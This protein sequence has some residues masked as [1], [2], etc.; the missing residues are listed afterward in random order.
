MLAPPSGPASMPF[1]LPWSRPRALADAPLHTR[2]GG[3]A[4]LVALLAL[5]GLMASAFWLCSRPPL[6]DLPQHLAAARV[7][8]DRAHPGFRFEHFFEVDWWRSQYLGTYVLLGGAFR[9]LRP[10]VDRPMLAAMRGVLVLL[11]FAWPL[12]AELMYRKLGRRAGLGALASVFFFNVHLILGFLNFVLGIVACLLALACL[13]SARA[14]ARAGR[15]SRLAT[16][17]WSAS[18][19]ACF[20]LHVVPFALLVGL[21]TWTATLEIGLALWRRTR[22]VGPPPG[23]TCGVLAQPYLA[24]LPALA[25][26]VAWLYTPAGVSTREAARGTGARG[27][28]VYASFESNRAELERWLVDAFASPWDTRWAALALGLLALWIAV[29]AAAAGWARRTARQPAALA[30]SDPT[31]RE[32]ATLAPADSRLAFD[33]PLLWAL[34]AF[35][36]AS[37]VLYFALPSSYDWIWPI[38]ARFPLL[39]AL[40]LPLWLP[41]PRARAA[42]WL[43]AVRAAALCGLMTCA[44]GEA[45]VARGAIAGFERESSGLDDVLA[46]IPQGQRTATLV[47]DRYSR[48]VGFAPFL[49]V[50]AYY[51]AERGGVSFFSF[52]D[53]PQSPIRF[54]DD[55]RPPRVAPRWEWLPERARE[56]DLAWFDYVITRGGPGRLANGKLFEPVGRFGRYRLFHKRGAAVEHE[57]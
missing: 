27:R 26:A 38:N 7:L 45:F 48:H 12:S 51:Q 57:P 21:A 24:L 4:S 22:D 10:F 14:A 35:V 31:P 44:A 29:E 25:A 13:A 30:S 37:L 50:G 54:R 9:A 46:A 40:A 52:A 11:A 43:R 2:A 23:P 42:A 34:R 20:Y 56:R 41:A 17:G 16:L 36:P 33:R 28:A 5:A 19:L 53:F 15:P 47:F 1:P 6:Q 18:A 39:G 49:H 3:V 55:D 8:F 32:S